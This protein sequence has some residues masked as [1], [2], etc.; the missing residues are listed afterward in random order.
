MRRLAGLAERLEHGRLLGGGDAQAR[1]SDGEHRLAGLAPADAELD[2]AALGELDGVAEQVVQHLADPGRVARDPAVLRDAGI[3]NEGDRRRRCSLRVQVG[4]LA[5]FLGEIEGR[6]ME[7]QAPGLDPRDVE[8]RADEAEQVLALRLDD[9]EPVGRVGV[10]V[11]AP[12]HRGDAEDAVQRRPQLVAHRAEE[13]R[14]DGALAAQLVAGFFE[15]PCRVRLDLQGLGQLLPGKELAGEAFLR[16]IARNPQLHDQQRQPGGCERTEAVEAKQKAH[17]RKYEERRDED[18]RGEQPHLEAERCH[19]GDDGEAGDQHG[20]CIRR[21][22]RAGEA[23]EAPD[24]SVERKRPVQEGR[25]ALDRGAGA[26]ILVGKRERETRR[27][28]EDLRREP[29]MDQERAEHRLEK[30]RDQPREC[31]GENGG[32]RRMRQDPVELLRAKARRPL[33]VED[34]GQLACRGICSFHFAGHS[35]AALANAA[36]CIGS[37][38]SEAIYPQ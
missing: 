28:A 27:G 36:R 7:L 23:C 18:R 26:G 8:Q 31:G 4:E 33:I 21:S 20:R 2:P 38:E 30:D 17:D 29:G 37:F 15:P 5:D 13:H 35:L 22:A 1:V 12:H 19:R 14:L 24:D 25:P 11:I 16:G 34:A 9:P 10:G 32:D 6:G 3:E